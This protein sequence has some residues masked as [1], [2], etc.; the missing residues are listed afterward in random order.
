MP[1]K[2]ILTRE[3]LLNGDIERLL[4]SEGVD[5]TFMTDEQRGELVQSTLDYLGDDGE[6][7]VFG[8]GSLIWNPSLNFGEQRRC[9][10]KGYQKKF[11]FW[12][13]LSRGSEE[14]PGLMVGLVEGGQCNGVAYKIERENTASELDILFRREMSS[15]VYKPTW[16]EACCVESNK[17]FNTLTF[18]V[19]TTNYRYVDDLTQEETVRAI[20]T[21]EGPLGRDCD[22]LFQLSENLQA[23]GFD[24]PVL[25]QLVEQVRVYQAEQ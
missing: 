20:A 3:A 10:I 21:A 17:R 16:I 8:Y 11:C 25:D 19:D 2:T 13:T 24:E 1:E 9:S 6:L 18:V 14:R 4:H 22:Y 23:L 12:T 15:Y 7:W 5:P